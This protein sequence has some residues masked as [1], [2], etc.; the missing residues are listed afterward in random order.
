MR[1][2]LPNVLVSSVLVAGQATVVRM[3]TA[4]CL[5]TVPCDLWEPSAPVVPSCD[6]SLSTYPVSHW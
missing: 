4:Q 5:L 6:A 1:H 3:D 2:L